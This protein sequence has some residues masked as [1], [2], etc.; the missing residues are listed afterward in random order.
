M[1]TLLHIF[2]IDIF[3]D[4]FKKLFLK[5]RLNLAIIQN[6]STPITKYSMPCMEKLYS[7]A[8]CWN[9]YRWQISFEGECTLYESTLT[10]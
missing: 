10:I 3:G 6:I 9:T 1:I 2:R 7:Q 8:K 5:V 4:A